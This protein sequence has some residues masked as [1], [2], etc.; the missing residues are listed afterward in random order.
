M[1]KWLREGKQT[2]I[3]KDI[4]KLAN[5]FKDEGL[6][7]LKEILI[8]YKDN[9]QIKKENIHIHDPNFFTRSA[10]QIIKSKYLI[11]GCADEAIF[12]V[13]LARA[14]KFLQAILRQCI[15]KA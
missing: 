9:L 2:K 5:T 6:G 4:K 3:T 1:H 12:F 14:K 10:E 11:A 8:W 13:T 15:K 7:Y